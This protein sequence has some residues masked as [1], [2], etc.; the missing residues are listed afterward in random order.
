MFKATASA[1]ASATSSATACCTGNNLEEATLN[2][3]ILALKIANI[4][5]D[6]GNLVNDQDLGKAKYLLL[7]CIDF[8]FIDNINFFAKLTDNANN[9]DMFVLAGSSLGYNGITGYHDW[10]VI[11]NQNIDLAIQL[12][13]IQEIFV[14]DHFDCGAYRLEYGENEIKNNEFQLHTDNLI[15]CAK[16]LKNIYPQLKINTAII[17]VEGTEIIKIDNNT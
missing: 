15:N 13:D 8:R 14:L 3:N 4:N 12:H 1:T 9:Y 11:C 7:A 2:A 6:G 10:D 5:L 17:N 16:K